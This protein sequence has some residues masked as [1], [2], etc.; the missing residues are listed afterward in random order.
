ME[1]RETAY[2]P[3]LNRGYLIASLLIFMLV[4]IWYLRPPL[5]NNEW[6]YLLVPRT[7]VDPG[8]LTSGA[9]ALAPS[10]VTAFWAI[11]AALFW[12]LKDYLLVAVVGRVIGWIFVIYALGRLCRALGLEWYVFLLGFSLWLLAGQSLAANE[13]IIQGVEQK[14]FA[15]GFLFLSLAELLRGKGL[16]AGLFCGLAIAFHVLVGGWGSMA[17]GLGG[18]LSLREFGKRQFLYFFGA[19]VVVGLPFLI[20]TLLAQA[21]PGDPNLVVQGGLDPVTHSV[22]FRNAQHLDP[23]YFLTVRRF[24]KLVLLSACALLATRAVIA[25]GKARLLLAFLGVPVGLYFAGVVARRLDSL[26]FLFVY[27]FRLGDVL[28]PLFFWLLASALIMRTGAAVLR[29]RQGAALPELGTLLLAGFCMLPVL[30]MAREIP[31]RVERGVPGFVEE[32]SQYLFG[33]V[34]PFD[35]MAAWI[36]ENTS[37][38]AIVAGPPC[39]GDFFLKAERGMVV[40]YKTG[41]SGAGTYDW[42]HR[43]E[44][45][46]DGKPVEVRGAAICPEIQENLGRLDEMALRNLRDSLGTDYYLS[47]RDRGPL[48]GGAV[49]QNGA[50]YLYDLRKLDPA[51][52][53]GLAE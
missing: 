16:T 30:E 13:W 23:D 7:L 27:P 12:I 10:S 44:L 37:P 35:D 14:V 33:P 1:P 51:P 26:L 34:D 52:A 39:R 29:A 53:P 25:S 40:S 17:L 20:L 4:S 19:S 6:V 5:T 18:L 50:Y 32:W 3:P 21:P 28:L 49:Y 41:P 45:L 9:F 31:R 43:M 8:F 42:L 36:K 2:L 48:A 11:G 38:A 22:L 24:L 15:Y 47:P 46:N